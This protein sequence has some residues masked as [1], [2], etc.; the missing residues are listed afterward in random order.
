[1]ASPAE[2]HWWQAHSHG[3]YPLSPNVAGVYADWQGLTYVVTHDGAVKG[4]GLSGVHNLLGGGIFTRPV[5]PTAL[6][7]KVTSVA[8]SRA[9]GF[10]TFMLLDDGTVWSAPGGEMVFDYAA[11]A[12]TP[13]F[14]RVADVSDVVALSSGNLDHPDGHPRRWHCLAAHQQEHLGIAEVHH[15]GDRHASCRSLQHRAG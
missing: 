9:N 3:R 2:S 14:A 1:M 12:F 8:V 5:A 15:S 7:G 10:A 6:P 13:K 4:W 11:N